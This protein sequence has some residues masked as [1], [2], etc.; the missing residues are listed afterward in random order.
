MITFDSEPHRLRV[1]SYTSLLLKSGCLLER[2]FL[3]FDFLMNVFLDVAVEHRRKRHQL[4]SEDSE[5]TLVTLRCC[6][7]IGFPRVLNHNP[8]RAVFSANVNK[9]ADRIK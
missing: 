1:L 9:H 5:R 2:Y 4:V 8:E 6:F 3:S 7:S